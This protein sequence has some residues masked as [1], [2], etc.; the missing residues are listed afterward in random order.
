M[1]TTESLKNERIETVFYLTLLVT[2]VQTG[3]TLLD[4]IIWGT[5]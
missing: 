5:L 2:I 4:N 3:F 1:A